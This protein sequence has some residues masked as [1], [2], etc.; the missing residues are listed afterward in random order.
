MVKN[1]KIRG[2][3]EL[4]GFTIP[5]VNKYQSNF[6][7][8][9][10]YEAFLVK[11]RIASV[12]YAPEDEIVKEKR[13][14][15]VYKTYPISEIKFNASVFNNFS[16]KIDIEKF[17]EQF[18]NNKL[19]SLFVQRNKHSFVIN[20][21]PTVV[22]KELEIRK[23]AHPKNDGLVIDSR[24]VGIPTHHKSS[25]IR[26]TV[27]NKHSV[28]FNSVTEVEETSSGETRFE[29]VNTPNDNIVANYSNI[30]RFVRSKYRD[31]IKLSYY[32]FNVIDG[33]LLFFNKKD[34]KNSET[35]DIVSL[36]NNF[37]ALEFA[38]LKTIVI[39][40]NFS[41]DLSIVKDLGTKQ[42]NITERF[43]SNVSKIEND[44]IKNGSPMTE[45]FSSSL[46]RI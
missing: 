40:D 32:D 30:I 29:S 3:A 34:N 23:N 16:F 7:P 44:K 36:G 6:Y 39:K 18:D 21:K 45:S 33:S 20:N 9:A 46:E 38:S 12:F 42:T 37:K 1:N 17:N 25:F 2:Y 43:S 11:P 5:E 35:S 22:N 31:R 19:E 15:N 4:S 24:I 28:S 8:T 14:Y 27:N 13:I 10:N 41:S 26:Y